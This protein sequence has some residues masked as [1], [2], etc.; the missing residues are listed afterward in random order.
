M[1]LFRLG[2]VNRKLNKTKEALENLEEA[3]EILQVTHGRDSAIVAKIKETI[4]EL[5][6]EE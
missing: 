1:Y 4:E 6:R 3:R 5:G 2:M